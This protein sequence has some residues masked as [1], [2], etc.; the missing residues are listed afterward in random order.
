MSPRKL[1]IGGY[2]PEQSAH[3]DGLKT[4]KRLVEEGTDGD[5]AVD[6]T[7]NIMAEGRPNTDLF[8]LVEAGHMF[9]C[10]FSSSYLGN[11]VPELDVLETPFLFPDLPTAH[12]ALDGALGEALAGAVR[13]RTGFDVLGFWDNGFRH[14][15]NRLRP[16]HRPADCEGMT[17]R[18]QPNEIHEELIRSWG[19]IPVAVELSAGIQL[20]TRL[21]VDAQENPLANT[22]AYGVDQVHSHFTMTG[23]L[24]GARGLFC[25]R[26]TLERF[27]PDLHDLVTQAATR[28]VEAQ[29]AAAADL[30]ESLRVRLEGAGAMFVELTGEERDEFVAVSGPAIELA[31]R[32]LP[33]G[34]LGLALT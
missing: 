30:E 8:E 31:H 11:R 33:D 24:Y 23:H 14:M 28:A 5:V 18:L 29:R 3:G 25:H 34:L 6:V 13:G 9:L 2:G 10:Y 20:I 22:V 15:T 26:P 21:D 12:Q 17:V 19:A 32:K 7:W 1:W 16:I 4:F 27:D